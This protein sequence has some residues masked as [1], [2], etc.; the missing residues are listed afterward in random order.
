MKSRDETL[1]NWKLEVMELQ[2]NDPNYSEG[3]RIME[4]RSQL[5]GG[6]E[7]CV[8]SP[9]GKQHWLSL[10]RWA[11]VDTETTRLLVSFKR[12]LKQPTEQGPKIVNDC[13]KPTSAAIIETVSLG[14]ASKRSSDLRVTVKFDIDK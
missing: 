14:K 10:K 12:V 2:P 11:D 1:G 13:A 9:D 6:D 5:G 3:I 8:T 7:G 4:L